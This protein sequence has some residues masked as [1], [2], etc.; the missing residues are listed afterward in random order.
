MDL[1]STNFERLKFS[2]LRKCQE[3]DRSLTPSLG[4]WFCWF[5]KTGEFH[6]YFGLRGTIHFLHF[7]QSQFLIIQGLVKFIFFNRKQ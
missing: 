5:E 3:G 4:L 2:W 1:I 6:L 7:L